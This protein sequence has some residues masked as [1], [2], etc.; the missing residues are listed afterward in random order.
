MLWRIFTILLV[1]EVIGMISSFPMETTIHIFT[2][3]ILAAI[4]IRFSKWLFAANIELKQ[5][6]KLSIYST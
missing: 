6:L 4:L 1:L 2:L 5:L 3:L